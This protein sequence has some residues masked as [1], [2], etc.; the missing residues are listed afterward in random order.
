MVAVQNQSF[1]D[2]FAGGLHS[3]VS[4][5]VCTIFRTKLFQN[6]AFSE[7]SFFRTK[8]FQNEAAWSQ[9]VFVSCDFAF[10]PIS[11]LLSVCLSWN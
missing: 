10:I 6:E 8:L 9:L 3:T 7:R 11:S 1:Q 2:G 5:G 4:N